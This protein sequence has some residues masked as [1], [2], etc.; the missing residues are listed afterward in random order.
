MTAPLLCVVGPTATGKTRL[1]IDVCRRWGAE[2]VGADASQVY[3]GMDIGTGKA[4]AAELGALRH[5]LID[6]AD[7]DEDFDV[8]AYVRL[9]DAAI[10]AARGRGARVVVCGGTGL[11]LR[12]LLHG[13]CAAPPVDAGIRAELRARI[14][15]GDV[16]A[17]HGELARVDPAAAARIAPRDRQRIERALGVF[18]TTGRALSSWQ[19]EHR[20]EPQRYAAALLGLDLPR[21][22]LHA[23][24]EARVLA[25]FAAGFVDEV[26]ALRARGHERSPR[27]MGALGYRAVA[28]ALDGEMSL[29]AA[30]E[31]T[32]I[33]TRRYARRQRTWFRALQDVRW[34]E[35]PI[36]SAEID[37][38][39]GGLW[40]G[41]T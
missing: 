19:A 30:R 15:A 14:D 29:E 38:Y 6:V 25:M 37:A 20:F 41:S 11:Y 10:E 12:A 34:M 39:L 26:R 9:A 28:A 35:P 40:G 22:Q 2:L 4:T 1:A 5:H 36:D 7:P 17:L 3:R 31:R 32:V 8:A 21:E 23:R 16:E 13:L 24:I 18:R 33:D 27:S